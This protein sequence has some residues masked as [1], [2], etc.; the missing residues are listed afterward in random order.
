MYIHSFAPSQAVKVECLSRFIVSRIEIICAFTLLLQK[1][2]TD[3]F[4]AD[5]AYV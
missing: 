2:I 5:D 4:E 1:S 3:L